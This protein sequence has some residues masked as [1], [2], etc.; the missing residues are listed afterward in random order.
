MKINIYWFRRDLRL[1]DN[2]ALE[3][4]L[5]E[6]LLYCLFLFLIQILLMN[7]PGMIPG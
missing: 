4:A 7:F 6:K 5:K 3:Q 1:E 2:T